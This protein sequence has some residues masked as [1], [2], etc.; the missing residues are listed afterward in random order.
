MNK[1]AKTERKLFLENLCGYFI[2]KLGIVAHAC[3]PRPWE[4]EARAE[5]QSHSLPHS[6][7]QAGLS[8]I[9]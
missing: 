2:T 7:S 6:E 9:R 1:K 4:T 5:V 8:Y 3:N